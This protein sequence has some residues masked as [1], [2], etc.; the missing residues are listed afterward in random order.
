MIESLK[1]PS[2]DTNT[3]TEAEVMEE[4]PSDTNTKAEVMEE[5]PSRLIFESPTMLPIL[6]STASESEVE[7]KHI[8]FLEEVEPDLTQLSR[9]TMASE[10]PVV[11][12]S[13][14]LKVPS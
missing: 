14:G 3:N 6:V 7:K 11:P 9:V 5:T 8:T 13:V 10:K 4:T 1:L 2:S 12:S